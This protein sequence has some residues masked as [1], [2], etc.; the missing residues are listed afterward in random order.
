MKILIVGDY[1][2]DPRLG[3]L[4]V[5]YKLREEFRNL[6]ETSHALCRQDIGAKPCNRYIL[7][8]F[9][10]TLAARAIAKAFRER[11]PYDVVGISSECTSGLNPVDECEFGDLF[12]RLAAR[13]T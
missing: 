2:D 13:T 7:Q 11:G 3:S 6:G 1:T 10:P 4:K 8:T 12:C 5:L 9:A